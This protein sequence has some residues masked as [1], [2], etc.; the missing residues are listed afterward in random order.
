MVPGSVSNP[1]GVCVC[2][3]GVGMCDES[4]ASLGNLKH[5]EQHSLSSKDLVP[6]GRDG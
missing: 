3:G 5:D 1:S 4:N 6:R 2:V